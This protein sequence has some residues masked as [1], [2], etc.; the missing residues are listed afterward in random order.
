MTKNNIINILPE[1]LELSYGN[2]KFGETLQKNVMQYRALRILASKENNW[3]MPLYKDF[4]NGKARGETR[5]EY[6]SRLLSKASATDKVHLSQSGVLDFESLSYVF[7]AVERGRKHD[8][9]IS[10]PS[11]E[12]EEISTK[13]EFACV[14]IDRVSKEISFDEEL[15]REYLNANSAGK[16]AIIMAKLKTIDLAL[17][18]KNEKVQSL[19]RWMPY[20]MMK[21]DKEIKSATDDLLSDDKN[22]EVLAQMSASFE[23]LVEKDIKWLEAS[24]GLDS[25]DVDYEMDS[26][27][28][29]NK[30]PKEMEKSG[31]K[32]KK[33]GDL[34]P[35]EM[36]QKQISKRLQPFNIAAGI[37]FFNQLLDA[38]QELEVSMD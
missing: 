31:S 29:Q 38:F 22:N 15:R 36:T 1:I 23:E 28:V 3:L 20:Y 7:D 37:K 14:I 18:D 32:T 4:V 27:D 8:F 16:N 21:A 19:N 17:N 6:V 34:Y 25:K 5:G 9:S 11:K 10:A 35:R 12:M 26:N 24:K 13:A 33:F 2:M 30:A